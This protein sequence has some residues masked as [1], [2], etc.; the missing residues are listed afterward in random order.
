MTAPGFLSAFKRVKP[1]K[2]SS[3]AH[4]QPLPD[5]VQPGDTS[6]TGA[7][8]SLIRTTIGLIEADVLRAVSD[9]SGTAALARG[10]AAEAASALA[11]IGVLTQRADE[12]AAAL[13]ADVGVMAQ[14]AAEVSEAAASIA[15]IMSRAHIE[16]DATAAE[17][18]SLDASIEALKAA[19]QEIEAILDTITGIARQTN[20]LALNAT[21]EAA[22]AGEAGRGFAVVAQEVKSLSGASERAAG[23]IRSRISTLQ[24]SVAMASIHSIE[25]TRRIGLVTPMFDEARAATATQNE[26]IGDLARRVDEASRMSS[27]IE[28]EMADIKSSARIAAE[29]SSA[30]AQSAE[31]AAGSVTDLSRRF[32]TVMRQTSMGDRRLSQRFPLEAQAKVVFAGGFVETLTID[33]SAGG[34]LLAGREGWAPKEGQQAEVKLDGIPPLP[35]RI[36]GVSPLG[37]HCMFLPLVPDTQAEVARR[38]ADIEAEAKPQIAFSQAAARQIGQLFEEALANGRIV[39]L[40]LYDIDYQAIAGTNPPQFT[41]RSLGRLEQWLTPLQEGWK[42]RDARIVFCCAVDRNGYLPVHNAVYSRPQR[43]DDPA[44]NTANSRNRRIFDD[45]AGLTCARTTQPIYIHAY[46]RD[47]GAGQMVVLKE[48]VAPIMV[49]G[50]HW[51][52][53]RCAYKL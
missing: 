1:S 19:S 50:R 40:D 46:K 8:A 53:F 33:I 52:G 16:S 21:I 3:V 14:S 38:L 48:F 11:D 37:A 49:N 7:S 25:V 23:D 45:R 6:E 22:R 31:A 18:L 2:V 12:S 47:M 34:L 13:S 43:P 9:V 20:L 27:A 28:R 4:A 39:E 51:G 26:A 10:A 42:A 5:T 35:V 29:R 15:D 41:T 44:W 32:V 17:T 36:V 24:K 30:A